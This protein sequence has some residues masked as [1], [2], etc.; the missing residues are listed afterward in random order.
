MISVYTEQTEHTEAAT[1]LGMDPGYRCS[2]ARHAL[3]LQ[4]TW[5]TGRADWQKIY[6]K[7]AGNHGMDWKNYRKTRKTATGDHG[8]YYPQVP[9][10]MVSCKPL[11][12]FWMG[13]LSIGWIFRFW[14]IGSESKLPTWVRH[15]SLH[16]YA[17]WTFSPTI[18]FLT[19]SWK[20][21]YHKVRFWSMFNRLTP[22]M[23][24]SHSILP[25]VGASFITV[26]FLASGN[27]IIKCRWSSF[28][29][30]CHG[31]VVVFP[32]FWGRTQM[33]ILHHPPMWRFPKMAA[34]LKIPKS[35]DVHKMF[36]RKPLENHFNSFNHWKMVVPH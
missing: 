13:R 2:A 14:Q 17:S 15:A 11:D 29:L 28:S 7:S 25:S 23:V 8:F 5:D 21:S 35:S 36:I 12:R 10:A 24:I 26:L 18:K 16:V 9:S 1:N 3:V 4:D 22:L 27:V 6:G 33:F 20:L 34:P 32:M 30:W 31:H 19:N